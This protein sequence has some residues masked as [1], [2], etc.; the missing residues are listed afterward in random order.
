M[1]ETKISFKP[2]KCKE[3][4]LS[5]LSPID[6]YV[7]FT[8]DT[9]KIYCANQNKFLPMGGNSG[10][11]YGNRTFAENETNTGETD[12]VFNMD[13]NHIEGD[14]VPNVNDLILNIPDGGFYRVI[15][16][17]GK[18]ITG[19]RLAVSGVGGGEGGGGTGPTSQRPL[20]SPAVLGT[21]Y[22]KLDDIEGMKINFTC[23]SPIDDGRNYIASIKYYFGNQDNPEQVVNYKFGEQI[24]FDISKYLNIFSSSGR[25]TLQVEVIDAYGNKSLKQSFYFYL[26]ELI[27]N[28]DA[29]PITKITKGDTNPYKYPCKPM[30][31]AGLENLFIKLK[32]SPLNNPQ[33]VLYTEQRNIKNVN[34]N[35]NFDI[36]FNSI[37]NS[38]GESIIEHG[39]YLLTAQFCGNV[40]LTNNI[41]AS[42]EQNVQIAIYD[43][44]VG[45]PLIATN[46]KN[47]SI[48]QYSQ[49]SL[50]YMIIN[51]S[52]VTEVNPL[53]YY[54][55]NYSTETAKLN[56][57]NIWTHT[58]I[59]PGVYDIAIQYEGVKTLLG[60]L[61]VTSYVGDI[62]VIDADAAEFYL[63][64]LG[65]SNTQAD[66]DVWESKGKQ[67]HLA[68]FENFLWGNEN[69]WV[70]NENNETALKITNGAKL[71]IPSY[72]PF[73]IDA[74]ENG[75]TIELDFMFSGVLDYSKPLIHCLSKYKNN[76]EERIQTGFNIT[77]QKATLNSAYYKA[78]TT[79]I[80]GEVG[81]DGNINEQD[82]ALQAFTQYFNEDTRIH[83]T[84]VIDR[85]PDWSLVGNNFYFVYTYLNGV[86]SGIMRLDVDPQN[87]TAD[88]FKDYIGAPSHMVFDSTYG[89]I[90]LYNIRVYRNALDMRTIINNYIADLSDIEKKV[91]LYKDN[92]IFTADG[93]INIKAIQD[94]S[95]SCR[96]PYVLFNGGNPMEKKFKDAFSFN[97]TY[98]LPVTKSDYRFMSMKM[99]DID[100]KT[101]ETYLALDIPI[102]AQN[103]NNNEDIVEKFDNLVV[104]TSYLPKRGVQVYGQGTSSMVYPVKNLRL[105]FIQENDFPQVYKGAYPTE[106]VCFKADFMDSSSAHNTC[107]GN[108]VYDIYQ[109]MNLK[110]PPQTFKINNQGKDGVAEYDLIT[111]IKG[112]P[113]VCFYAP[114]DSNDYQFIGRYNFNID[115]ATPEPFGFIP[116]K[117]YTGE[118]V[119]DINGNIRKVVN[120]CGLKTEIVEGKT[121]LP[122]DEE[123]KEIERDIVQCWEILNNDNGSPTKFL[124]LRDTNEDGTEKYA[125]FDA[126]LK[127]QTAKGDKYNWMEY[128]EDRYPDAIVAGGKNLLGDEEEDPYE[129][130]DEDLNNGLFRLANWINSTSTRDGDPTGQSLDTPVFYQTMDVVWNK[131]KIYYN[132][133]GS[134]HPIIIEQ[135]TKI[136]DTSTIESSLT[137]MAINKNI[138]IDKVGNSEFGSYAF[139]YSDSW[140]LNGILVDLADYGISFTGT[141]TEGNSLTVTYFETNNWSN[142]LYDKFEVDNVTY[143]LSKFKTEF[144][145]YFNM[146]FS[147][148]YYVMTLT[149]LMMDS[150]AKNMMLASWDQTVWYPIFYDMDT[151]LGVNNT[152]FNKFSFDTED[153]PADKVFNGFDSV[154]WN[155]FRTCFSSRIADF[156]AKMRGSMTLTKLLETYNEKGT[157]AWNEAFCSSDAYYKYERP[158]KEGYYDGK[159]GKEIPRGTISYLYAAQ[160]RRSNHRA[161]WLNN[162]LNYLDSKYIPT[163]YG[164]EKPSQVN[165]FS[166]R[167]YALPEQKNTARA[168]KCIAQTPPNHQFNLKA[169]NNSYQSIF[170]G[171]IVYGPVYTT[172]GQIVTLGPEEVKH[173]VESYILNP[174]LIADLGDL[175][176]KYI[177]SLNF[178]GVQ[179]RL[180]ELKLGRSSRSHPISYDCYYNNLLS[181]LNLGASCPYLQKVNI[182]RCTGLRS[183]SFTECPRLQILDAEGSELTNINFPANSILQ[184][185]YVPNSLDSLTLTNQPYLHTIKFDESASGL[186]KIVLD[187]IPNCDT[188]EL[189]KQ[190]FSTEI[191]KYFY[192]TNINWNIS[193][194][195]VAMENGKLV[196]IDILDIL[197]SDKAYPINENYSKAQSLSG[198]ITINIPDIKVDEYEIYNKYKKNFP[199]ITIQYGD[200]IGEIITAYNLVFKTSNDVDATIHYAVK[201]S[202]EEGLTLKQLTS[203]DGPTGEDMRVPNRAST[204]A[205][206]YRFTG[207]WID[208]NGIFY[209]TDKAIED[210]PNAKDFNTFSDYTSDMIFYPEYEETD[211][212]Y[213]VKFY[214]SEGK[215]VLQ[216]VYDENNNLIENREAWPVKYNEI[217]DG[218]IQNFLYKDDSKLADNLRYSFLGWSGTNYGDM[219][220]INPEYINI[221]TY[222]ITNSLTLYPHYKTEDAYKVASS[223]EYFEII[224]NTISLKE[225]YM[226][227]LQGKIT[228]PTVE[229]VTIVGSFKGGYFGKQ[230]KITHIYFLEDSTI[231][232]LD[233]SAFSFMDNLKVIKLPNSLTTINGSAFAHCP[234]LETINLNDE[235]T[236]IKNNAFLSCSKLQLTSLPKKLKELGSAAFQSAGEG[237][238]ITEL[239]PELEILNSWTFNGCSNVKIE[240][241]GSNDSTKSRLKK[242]GIGC[243]QNS[244]NG[245]YEHTVNYINIYNSV[246][247]IESNAFEG[248]LMNAL[249]V[250]FAKSDED[251]PNTFSDI[252]FYYT[253]T[254]EKNNPRDSR[255]SITYSYDFDT[256]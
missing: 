124:K 96:V 195:Q 252:G 238:R 1:T 209:K 21:Q 42:N 167:A 62:P 122:I 55:L 237:I 107:T 83:L 93:Y 128:Y 222:H 217:Y 188:Y 131:D 59:T 80:F 216:P 198:T 115:K 130:Y 38:D 132:A 155:N 54:G 234:N 147:L 57:M 10:V 220:V 154:L 199:N 19:R 211:R 241:F 175:S 27:L 168:E 191:A 134:E 102:E 58:F 127:A 236:S 14:Q 74:I 200:N 101:G 150:R 171:N 15:D 11:Y 226:G 228:I 225:Q 26:I 240:N 113:I 250:R 64:A 174:Q 56:E 143:R 165:T 140:Y 126:C 135:G 103:Q 81:E 116:Q 166:F 208:Q 47:G 34:T 255:F 232:T 145:Q 119:T 246:T 156:Y 224:G 120:V 152:G 84:Y 111:A 231:T 94:L 202:S 30:G 8:T 49:F 85:V 66:K 108:L 196:G 142:A 138:F 32:L 100:E 41:I 40:P 63:T 121:V 98:A 243:F 144:T 227:T 36:D 163:T 206:D 109:A 230:S 172:A 153:D 219:T 194:T 5:I 242:I 192:L 179:T 65:K 184:E 9:Q 2:V 95:Y 78:T 72:N 169:L 141:P 133:D 151:M 137:N 46:F 86:L 247:E 4:D 22:F 33:Q 229:G 118:T 233:S 204:Q 6:G 197:L 90:Y 183:V 245:D 23:S 76:N 157:D 25:N 52:N 88:S 185:V 249:G 149:L 162:R 148:F 24:T 97:K 212:Y 31:G 68:I 29:T 123:G 205:Y 235:I 158:Y 17:Y 75:L 112:F 215:I 177:G 203:A 170:I 89:D 218:P 35:Y 37:V 180:T 92:N 20:I 239:P 28:S 186:T 159:D 104:G 69:G 125:T 164:D 18:L 110:T 223:L 77:G 221:K 173:E 71:E 136:E 87:K 161:W 253:K 43:N 39:V 82:M 114:G 139:L 13:E 189:V 190:V 16:V 207:Y 105:K 79:A 3:S 12:F 73:K 214:D 50:Q 248:Y 187:N 178:P 53:I 45:T 129:Y 251:Y 213:E 51:E 182:A 254:E 44:E 7:Y 176:N 48:M 99:Y 61:K 160:G 244:G 117:I 181:T 91:E 193:D 256:E 146:E 60:T 201:A 210:K 70:T 106:I 67:K